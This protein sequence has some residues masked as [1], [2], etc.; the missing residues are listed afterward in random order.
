MHFH[1]SCTYFHFTFIIVIA[2]LEC[3]WTALGILHCI[4]RQK[5]SNEKCD[6]FQ[7]MKGQ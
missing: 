1:L 2:L 4:G 5:Q 6:I 7:N 3:S